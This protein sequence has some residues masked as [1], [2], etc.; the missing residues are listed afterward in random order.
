M[1]TANLDKQTGRTVYFDYLRVFAALAV[2]ILHISAQ[3]WYSTDVNQIEWQ[4]F[5]FFDSIVRW[6]VP[7][8][9]MIS[10]SLFL[11]NEVPIKRLYLKY[12]LRMVVAF[13]FWSVIYALFAD[14]DKAQ[15]I[16]V[17]IQGHYHMWFILTIIG[18]YICVPLIKPI[19]SNDDRIRYFLMLSLLFTFIIPQTITLIN[20]FGRGFF[21]NGIN[22]VKSDVDNMNLH[23]VIGY[24]GYFILGYYMNRVD[25]T[26]RQRVIIY[27]LGILGFAFTVMADLAVAL[28]TQ[29]YCSHYYSAFTLNVLF[30]AVAVFT[31]FKY[32]KYNHQRLNAAAQK[33]SRYSFGAYL[34]HALIIEQLN[35]RLG[36]NTLSFHPVLSVLFIAAITFISSFA[37]SALLNHIPIIKKYIV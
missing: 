10:G 7:V 35:F 11:T 1:N 36:I 16:L 9:F 18:L 19:V 26:R 2:M 6:G 14:L 37:I 21:I 15:R 28:K 23:F 29:A 13:C 17:T 22:A 20:D 12:I 34:V 8:F 32:R 27:I 4:T 33:L 25:L 3:N 30:E 31:W 24:V 5:N